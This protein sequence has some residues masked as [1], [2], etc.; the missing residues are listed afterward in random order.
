LLIGSTQKSSL[1]SKGDIPMLKKILL[2]GALAV[3][4]FVSVN[5]AAHTAATPAPA[6]PLQMAAKW[7]PCDP[8]T[9]GGCER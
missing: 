8:W 4:S 5:M 7:P 1:D 2:V 3:A 6:A 9:G